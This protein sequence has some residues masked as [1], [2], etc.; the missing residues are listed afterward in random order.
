MRITLFMKTRNKLFHAE[1]VYDDGVMIVRKGSMVNTNQAAHIRGENKARLYLDDPQFVDKD[2]LV[3]KDCT[4]KSPS[5]A[6]QFVNGNCTNGY[7]AWKT[8][9]GIKL[10]ELVKVT[11]RTR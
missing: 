1:A 11:E 9:D 7:L 6:A 8:R 4:F 3:L 10:K 5:A 2:G